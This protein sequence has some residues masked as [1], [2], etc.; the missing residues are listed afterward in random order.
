[1]RYETWQVAVAG[2]IGAAATYSAVKG[3]WVA[4]FMAFFLLVGLAILAA[5][6]G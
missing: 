2:L 6:D 3:W 5:S 4:D 1:M